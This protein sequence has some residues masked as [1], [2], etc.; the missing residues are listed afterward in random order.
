MTQRP[1]L[2]GTILHQ[3]EFRLQL[4]Q[5]HR[6]HSGNVDLGYKRCRKNRASSTAGPSHIGDLNVFV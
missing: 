3:A 6:A 4:G 2:A 1:S 5:S